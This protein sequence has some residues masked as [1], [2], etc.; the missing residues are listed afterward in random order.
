M[1]ITAVERSLDIEMPDTV[2]ED[3]YPRDFE[4]ASFAPRALSTMRGALRSQAKHPLGAYSIILYPFTYHILVQPFL[5]SFVS[6]FVSMD[7]SSGMVSERA[8]RSVV[9]LLWHRIP[10]HQVATS[11]T[12]GQR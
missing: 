8:M 5:L 2:D 1:S 6:G 12:G 10:L 4:G 11:I 9:L 3:P 7:I